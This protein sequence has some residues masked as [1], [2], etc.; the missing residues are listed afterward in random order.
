MHSRSSCGAL[1]AAAEVEVAAAEDAKAAENAA[2]EPAVEEAAAEEAAHEA[3][4]EEAAVEE[5]ATAENTA[6]EPAAEDAAAEEAA[7]EAAVEEAAEDESEF[8]REDEAEVDWSS[9]LGFEPLPFWHRRIAGSVVDALPERLHKELKAMDVEE[10]T[11]C[12]YA[13]NSLRALGARRLQV[14]EGGSWREIAVSRDG[15]CK[16]G[17]LGCERRWAVSGDGL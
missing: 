1:K 8:T 9:V 3:A 4:A 10:I 2:G 6:G 13:A 16:D 15:L 17:L 5:A 12:K 14:L 11:R 7:P